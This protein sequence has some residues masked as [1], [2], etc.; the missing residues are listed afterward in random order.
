MWI[1]T[2]WNAKVMCN[3]VSARRSWPT[4]LQRWERCISTGMSARWMCSTG[5]E[6]SLTLLKRGNCNPCWRQRNCNKCMCTP[7]CEGHVTLWCCQPL[8]DGFLNVTDALISAGARRGQVDACTVLSYP[9]TISRRAAQ[10]A[11]SVRDKVIPKYKLLWRN[12]IVQCHQT[13]GLMTTRNGV[14]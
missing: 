10:V 7:L 14:T 11:K 2:Q 3:V 12:T 13:C 6:R 4:I 9:T 5:K 8:F 1:V